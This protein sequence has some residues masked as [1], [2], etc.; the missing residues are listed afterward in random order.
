MSY[1]EVGDS[2]TIGGTTVPAHR[3]ERHDLESQKGRV[4]R[5]L[6]R[7]GYVAEPHSAESPGGVICR[8][9]VAPSLLV[10]DDGRMELLSGQPAMQAVRLSQSSLN[11]IRWRR[12]L[13][14]LALL[15]G[16]AFLGLLMVAMVV[17]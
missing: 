14:V 1:S 11:P 15:C 7:H 2:M 16:A 12:A 13:L 17:G 9:A 6:E 3:D 10:H 4:V 5:E 8:H